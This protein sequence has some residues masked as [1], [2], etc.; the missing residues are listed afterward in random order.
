MA[1]HPTAI[2]DRKAELDETV[3]VGPFCVIDAYVKVHAGCKL[4]Q[5]VYLTGWTDIAEGCILHPG[6]IVGHEPQDTKYQGERSFCR[7]GRDTIVRENVTIHRGA[8]PGSQTEVGKSCFLLAG[9]HV[10]HNCILGDRVTLTNGVLLGGHVKIGDG[11]NIGGG[12][13]I[14]QFVRI[15]EGCMVAGLSAV[16]MDIIPFAMVDRTGKIAGINRIGLRRAGVNRTD[17]H[18]V[19]EAYRTLFGLGLPFKEAV[20]RLANEADLGFAARIVQ[21]LRAESK[22]GIAGRLESKPNRSTPTPVLE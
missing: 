8:V 9:S 5:G 20:D 19:R 12:T 7:I 22:R 17:I 15:G 21:F 10:A 14:H 13:A 3:E 16:T 18:Q 6:A 4:H 2:V 1:I 11:T